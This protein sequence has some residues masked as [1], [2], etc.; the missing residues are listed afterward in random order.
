[1]TDDRIASLSSLDSWWGSFLI[2][3]TVI[4]LIGV[5]AEALQFMKCVNQ[6]PRLKH[7]LELGAFLVL[8]VGTAGE[9]L[10]ES[11]TISVGDRLYGLL[12]DKAGSANERAGKADDRAASAEKYAAKSNER[13]RA[14]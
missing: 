8:I 10:G 11:K 1:M 12:N 3:S 9:L 4:V 2:V 14:L 5:A 7:S 6:R 13:A